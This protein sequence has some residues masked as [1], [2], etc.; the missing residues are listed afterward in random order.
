MDNPG[1]ISFKNITPK[2]F[3]VKNQFQFLCPNSLEAFLSKKRLRKKVGHWSRIPVC[4]T[5]LLFEKRSVGGRKNFSFGRVSFREKKGVKKAGD[6][7]SNPPGA[8]K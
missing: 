4:R 2:A 8:I 1:K 5:A 3:K 7:G 6:G